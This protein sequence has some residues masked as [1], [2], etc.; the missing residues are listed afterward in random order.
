MT[1]RIVEWLKSLAV[2]STV[3]VRFRDE[4]VDAIVLD[5][6]VGPDDVA[7]EL[8]QAAES[9]AADIGRTRVYTLVAINE[10]GERYVCPLR[11]R[12]RVDRSKADLVGTL[13]KQNTDLV[14][15]LRKERS[16]SFR[17]LISFAETVTKSHDR[18]VRENERHSARASE[19]IDK[20]EAL[21]TK[22]LERRI[23]EEKHV[24]DT[25][26]KERLTDA[27]VP[28]ALAIGHKVSGGRLPG[29]DIKDVTLVQIAKSLQPEQLDRLEIVLGERWPVM[30]DILF[31]ALDNQADVAGFCS[32]ANGLAPETIAAVAQVLNMGQQ[33]A[34]KELLDDSSSN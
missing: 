7:E 31:H 8:D 9:D 15:T 14:D 5:D 19:V 10:G 33:A 17:M 18:L 6:R 2:P 3:E 23:L 25:E 1:N 16:E 22:D 27:F 24:A 34:L 11:I 29:P 20:L 30:R 12:K 32:F 21:R 13:A 26:M 28:L 4:I